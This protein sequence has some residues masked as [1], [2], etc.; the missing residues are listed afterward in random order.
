MYSCFP[1]PTAWH[2]QHGAG[3]KLIELRFTF[4]FTRG[5]SLWMSGEL[6]SLLAGDIISCWV[7]VKT[8]K[9]VFFF[10]STAQFLCWNL[11]IGLGWELV[12][13][14]QW[15]RSRRYSFNAPSRT[16]SAELSRELTFYSL[17]SQ[18]RNDHSCSQVVLVHW[19]VG[20]PPQHPPQQ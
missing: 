9:H 19:W 7:S 17:P 1:S 18:S 11:L 8:T 2:W 13:H 3:P 16:D 15:N 14:L 4:L 6:T 20:L 5:L 10:P 12:I